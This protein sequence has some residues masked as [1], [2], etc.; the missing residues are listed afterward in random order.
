MLEADHT[1]QKLMRLEDSGELWLSPTEQNK[2]LSLKLTMETGGTL[3]MS[4]VHEINVLLARVLKAES[5]LTTS[6]PMLTVAK[7]LSDLGSAEKMLDD[8]ERK[9]Y[10]SVRGKHLSRV[11]LD[12]KEMERLLA[13]H[14]DKGF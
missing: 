1:Y 7:I 4:A 14:A 5:V 8:V 3:P 12:D 6:E 10:M 9:F 11:K 13:I 2:V